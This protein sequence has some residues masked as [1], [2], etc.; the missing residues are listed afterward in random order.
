[1]KEA[2]ENRI[3]SLELH[4]KEFNKVIDELEELLRQCEAT[5]D[6]TT[7]NTAES[8]KVFKAQV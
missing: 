7:A 3:K 2:N 6:E 5:K 8:I 4:S 1:M